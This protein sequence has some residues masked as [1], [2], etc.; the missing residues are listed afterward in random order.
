VLTDD[1]ALPQTLS[2]GQTSALRRVTQDA[3]GAQPARGNHR[4]HPR[5]LADSQRQLKKLADLIV[6]ESVNYSHRHGTS[7]NRAA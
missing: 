4:T 6:A 7:L 1:A 2:Q 5:K 3:G